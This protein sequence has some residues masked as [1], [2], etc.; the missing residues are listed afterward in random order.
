[1]LAFNRN[2]FMP[3]ALGQ[4][5]EANAAPAFSPKPMVE[6][7]DVGLRYGEVLAL[8]NT[9]MSIPKG[10][11]VAVVGPAVAGNPP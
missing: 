11:F 3:T 8:A 6:L 9:T 1:L 5:A 10:G 2:G 4:E 7:D